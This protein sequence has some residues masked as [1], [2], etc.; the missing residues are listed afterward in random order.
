M[1][2]SVQT[3]SK[4]R[5]GSMLIAAVMLALLA[6]GLMEY[7]EHGFTLDEPT[8]RRTST[9]NYQYIVKALTGHEIKAY[10]VELDELRDR[11]YG[12][13]LQLPMVMVEHLNN[14]E[15]HSR[16]VYLM[17]H[18][19]TFL[20]CWAG[21]VCFYFFC[22][23]IFHSRWLG[24]LGM[25]MLALY[26]RF[27]GEQFTNIKDMVFVSTVCAAMLATVCCLEHED[28]RRYGLLAAVIYAL[29][30]NTRIVGVMI[31]LLLLGY[32]LVRDIWLCRPQDGLWRRIGRYLA[33]FGLCMAV[34]VALM[35][36]LWSNPIAG[37]AEVF[38]TFSNFNRW[39]GKELFCGTLTPQVPWYYLPV[40][41]GISLPLWYLAA[42][43]GFG[44]AF[45]LNIRQAQR[46]K[47]GGFWTLVLVREKYIVFCLVLA[48]CPWVAAVVNQSTLYNGWRHFYFIL[49]ALIVLMLYFIGWLAKRLSARGRLRR[50]LAALLCLLLGG[51]CAFIAYNH[52][53]EKVYFNPVG[54][55]VADGFSRDYWLEATCEQVRYILAHD[56]TEKIRIPY[57]GGYADMLTPEE[58]ARL[59]ITE[60]EDSPDY[61][62]DAYEYWTSASQV[63][64]AGYTPWHTIRVSGHPISTVFIRDDLLGRV[65]ASNEDGT[66]E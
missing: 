19:F 23:K 28:K 3:G 47:A 9:V 22:Q 37:I 50:A 54:I 49:P 39:P 4:G 6:A 44:A 63:A 59:S 26:P 8:E 61:I 29:C 20:I 34:Y 21:Y 46:P 48:V 18:L 42:L 62:I 16:D 65:E 25:L 45:A 51:Q 2:V 35:P 38:G 14:F 30:M 11:Y 7:G 52:P 60:Q 13:A 41:L 17:R 31:P 32:R 55:A 36:A 24:L 1:S 64:Y 15:L 27:W 10:D 56:P 33:Q 40:W 57:Y 53:F 43:M 5:L 12:V 66:S 58:Q